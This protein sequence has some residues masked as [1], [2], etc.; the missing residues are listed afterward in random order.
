MRASSDNTFPG[1]PICRGVLN[2]DLA[3]AMAQAARL[4]STYYSRMAAGCRSLWVA[5]SSKSLLGLFG[6]GRK[7][8]PQIE[9]AYSP[10]HMRLPSR[11][12]I[13][14]LR[15]A[16]SAGILKAYIDSRKRFKVKRISEATFRAH[17]VNQALSCF[18]R[19]LPPTTP[20]SPYLLVWRFG[21]RQC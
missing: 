11:L 8:R 19:G 5:K 15:Q 2:E 13:T 18:A 10:V 1:E 9:Q 6:S 7:R 17:A 4:K 14:A 3:N 16:F 12:V 20:A 21:C